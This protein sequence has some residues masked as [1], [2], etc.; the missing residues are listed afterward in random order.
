MKQSSPELRVVTADN[1]S[2]LITREALSEHAGIYTCRAENVVGS[3]TCTATLNVMPDT[4]WEDVTEL[5]SP[6]FVQKL[7]NVRVM[8][9]EEVH[10]TCQVSFFVYVNPKLVV[11][12]INI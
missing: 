10:F 2:V 6:T 8:D 4:E 12:C 9:G 3:V 1:H 7:A 11:T 5:A